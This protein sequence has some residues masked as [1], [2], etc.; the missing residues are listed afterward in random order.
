MFFDFCNELDE[1]LF[2]WRDA[3]ED[4]RV[5]IRLK[6]YGEVDRSTHH[7]RLEYWAIEL[8]GEYVGLVIGLDEPWGWSTLEKYITDYPKYQALVAY[9]KAMYQTK[10]EEIVGETTQ[11]EDLDGRYELYIDKRFSNNMRR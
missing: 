1:E 6:A 11:I 2:N 5:R 8:D 4:E 3:I 10:P 7:E 9:V